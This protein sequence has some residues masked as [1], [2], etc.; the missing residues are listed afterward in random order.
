LPRCQRKVDDRQANRH[1]IDGS[2]QRYFIGNHHNHIERR[3]KKTVGAPH[4][5][6]TTIDYQHAT[7]ISLAHSNFLI[8]A[9]EPHVG[10]CL[11]IV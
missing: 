3:F 10:R 1:P 6:V 8:V 9:I 7:W 5:T 11:A 2:G 4:Q